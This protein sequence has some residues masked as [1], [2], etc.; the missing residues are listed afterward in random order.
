MLQD[1]LSSRCPYTA[2]EDFFRISDARSAAVE[3]EN[4]RLRARLDAAECMLPVMRHEL[5]ATK[6][7]LGLWSPDADSSHPTPYTQAALSPQPPTTTA[8]IRF[9]PPTS[10]TVPPYPWRGHHDAPT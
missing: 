10:M 7:A 3:T 9:S 6:G 5:Q 2:L 8:R 4:V 1:T